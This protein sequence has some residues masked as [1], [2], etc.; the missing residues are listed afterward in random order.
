[1]YVLDL[2][3]IFQQVQPEEKEEIIQN[4]VKP[5]IAPNVVE[6][7]KTEQKEEKVEEVVP[8]VEIR[9]E[10]KVLEE[11]EKN[12]EKTKVMLNNV[13]EKSDARKEPELRYKYKEGWFYLRSRTNIYRKLY[14]YYKSM[15]NFLS[16]HW[17]DEYIIPRTETC[18]LDMPTC[19]RM[20]H[21]CG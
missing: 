13:D 1:M 17:F 9:I 6:P 16:D 5:D 4:D 18:F 2:I 7:E 12:A 10:D 11:N 21:N 15:M 8:N 20:P 3:L 19:T 14:K